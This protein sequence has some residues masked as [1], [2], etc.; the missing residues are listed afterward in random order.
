[1][2]PQI[3]SLPM[4]STATP[5]LDAATPAPQPLPMGLEGRFAAL[6]AAMEQGGESPLPATHGKPLPLGLLFPAMSDAPGAMMHTSAAES[7]LTDL[8][9]GSEKPASDEE[10]AILRDWIGE[11]LS[12]DVAAAA[13]PRTDLA[14]LT[15]LPTL[16]VPS[17]SAS[18]AIETGANMNGVTGAAA[19]TGRFTAVNDLEALHPELKIRV[20]RVITRMEREFGHQV[21]V[22]ETRRSQERQDALYAQGRT[23]PGEIVTW[24]RESKH[25]TGHAA[26]LQVDGRWDNPEA[27]ARLQRIAE[28]E[29]LHTLGP[30]DGGHVEWR[31]GNARTAGEA[32]RGFVG[33]PTNAGAPA[34]VTT[35][36]AAQLTGTA[37]VA[38]I[39]RVATPAAIARVATV[40]GS[41]AARATAPSRRAGI[42]TADATS[43][44]A[45]SASLANVPAPAANASPAPIAFGPPL[46][47]PLE[48]PLEAP[49]D[50]SSRRD[51]TA[52]ISHAAADVSA[53]ASSSP[54]A[55]TSR[56]THHATFDRSA[57]APTVG[58]SRENLSAGD[59]EHHG[60]PSGDAGAA[61][62]SPDASG[63]ERP[64]ESARDVGLSSTASASAARDTDAASMLDVGASSSARIAHLDAL[65]EARRQQPLQSITLRVDDAAGQEHRIRVDLRGDQVHADITT[66]SGVQAR[67]LADA[68][69]ELRQRLGAQGLDT[70]AVQVRSWMNDVTP[71]GSDRSSGDRPSPEQ[72]QRDGQ[73]DTPRDDAE[74]HRR[75]PRHSHSPRRWRAT[76]G[77][78]E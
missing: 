23:A 50:A 26:D 77:G 31:T 13:P 49:L 9:A 34:T 10:I 22:V 39:A 45:P 58:E 12:R 70:G 41:V 32:A 18:D 17:A 14:A 51:A 44:G 30:R 48:A 65:D 47:A 55:H 63:M 62:G 68:L 46:D 20:E 3:N 56:T 72:Q 74:A 28:S 53:I 43:S 54:S 38:D 66:A 37:R 33:A 69:P 42:P 35:P 19:R 27:Y 76:E 71:S 40:G 16:A 24:T 29:G 57:D 73:R 59:A 64:I 7:P 61:F 75:D 4:L 78:M 15:A 67:Q 60:E 52:A 6:L 21:Q 2:T 8:V 11:I 1:V 25:S 5:A 36:A